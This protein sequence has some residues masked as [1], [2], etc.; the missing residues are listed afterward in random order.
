MLASLDDDVRTE[1]ARSSPRS[2][3]SRPAGRRRFSTSA[4]GATAR[5]GSCSSCRGDP[6]ARARARRP[7]LGGFGVGRAARRAAAPT[8]GAPVLAGARGAA[9]PGAR[10]AVRGAR[11][12][13]PRRHARPDRA[14]RADA[15]RGRRV[16]RRRRRGGTRPPRSTRR[17]A[18]TRSTS[19][20]SRR[21][22]E[23]PA[24]R[25]RVPRALARRHRGPALGCCRAGGGVRAALER[26]TARARG[27]GRRRRPV[28]AGAGGGRGRERAEAAAI[29]ALDEL[30]RLDLVRQTDVPRRFRFRHP[31]VRR[32]VYE[33]TP[34]RLAAGRARALRRAL[35]ARGAPVAARAHHV[36]RSARQG[37]V[38]RRR[39]PAR[40]RR[41]GG[42][43]RARERGAL[44]RGRAQ[45]PSRG[46]ARRGAGGAA[47]RPGGGA[48]RHRP[49]R[50]EPRRPAGVHRARAR[51]DGCAARA[52]H[53]GVRRRRAPARAP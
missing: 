9:A 16:P 35:A 25:A 48:R 51:R 14:R 3:A 41:G 22:S 12:R 36:E 17:A 44:V 45:P 46:R 24:A 29:E 47:A 37:D 27:R 5:S 19:S 40:G 21:S 33:S 8:A 39:D 53:D 11:A 50:R 31:L 13:T 34:G 2:P 28:R 52:A 49:V 6:A 7:S 4:T 30:L 18:A 26:R 32:A 38:G 15:R 42:T 43:A 1:L 23:R 10:A 20:S